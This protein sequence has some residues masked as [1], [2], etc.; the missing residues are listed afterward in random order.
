LRPAMSRHV[1]LGGKWAP[2]RG[3]QLE[4]AAFRADTRDELAIATNQDGRSTYRNVGRTRR[5]GIE[6][7]FA[8]SLGR[9]WQ[10]AAG[11]TWLD[12]R[13]RTPFLAC[14]GTPCRAPS[15]PV[16]A[17]RPLPGVPNRYGSLRCQHGRDTGWHEGLELTGASGV[18]V[19]DLGTTR[20]PGYV[21]A[22][23]DVG[24]RFASAGHQR[25]QLSARVDNIA[26]R[27]YIGSVIV[28]DGNGRYFEPGPGRTVTLGMTLAF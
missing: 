21:L 18:P 20:A 4:A 28:N 19:N 6:V 5:Q 15:A 26:D 23:V 11:M 2:G 22:G 27:A 17:G 13:F 1:E 12:A 7:S 14:D 24:Y 8:G 3:L 25:L 16:P 10:L 9:D